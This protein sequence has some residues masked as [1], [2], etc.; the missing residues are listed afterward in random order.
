LRS[1]QEAP[2]TA[3]FYQ[4]DALFGIID[5]GQDSQFWLRIPVTRTAPRQLLR[6]PL[7]HPGRPPSST[8]IL[9]CRF[10]WHL[11]KYFQMMLNRLV[12]TGERFNFVS[13][14]LNLSFGLKAGELHA[15]GIAKVVGQFKRQLKQNQAIYI[16]QFGFEVCFF[17]GHG[18]WRTNNLCG[19]QTAQAFQMA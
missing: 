18:P 15:K 19:T 8:N 10:F 12:F 1:E 6:T 16:V 2:L 11:E 9:I 7:I 14:T 17:C 5:A 13:E 3:R 4:N